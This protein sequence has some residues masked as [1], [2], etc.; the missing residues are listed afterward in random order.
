MKKFFGI[1]IFFINVVLVFSSDFDLEELSEKATKN[2]YPNAHEVLVKRIENIEYFR[3]GNYEKTSEEYFKILDKIGKD[4]NKFIYDS[5][6]SVYSDKKF[7]DVKII[8]DGKVLDFDFKS[9]MQLQDNPSD[10]SSN[11]YDENEKLIVIN[12]PDLKIGD[13]IYTKE[14]EKSKKTRMKG[15]YTDYIG[16]QDTYP[17][18]YSSTK[19]IGPMDNQLETSRVYDG[20]S[21]N[22]K[23]ENGIEGDKRWYRFT[24]FNVPQINREA[25]MP[26][27]I[28]VAMRWSVS[29]IP[30]WEEISKWY[31]SLSEPKIVIDD[32]VRRAASEISKNY[33][34]DRDK[35]KA[36]F[37]WVS[38]NVR[39]MGINREKNRPGLE[40][41]KSIYTLKSMTGVCRDKAALI[42]AMLRSLGY[43]SNMV[44]M[45]A[46]RQMEPDFP[47]N[48]FNHAIA[49]V[50]LGNEIILMDPTDETTKSLMPEYLS[51]RPYLVAKK[52]GD[53]LRSNTVVK[54]FSNELSI[55]S[56]VRY[57]GKEFLVKSK[58]N[59][60]GIND[61]SYRSYLINLK[62]DEREKFLKN[63]LKN[64]SADTELIS[65]KINP[66]NLLDDKDMEIN[67]EYR[68]KDFVVGDEYRMFR[69]PQLSGIFGMHNWM[70]GEFDL[71]ERRYPLVVN[72]TAS[73]REEVSVVM[74]GVNFLNIP[75]GINKNDDSF[76]FKLSYDVSSNKV[77][78][79]KNFSL[80]KLRYST[81]DYYEIRGI[82]GDIENYDKKYIIVKK[83]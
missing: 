58:L 26:S 44:L 41:H 59:F 37:F 21:G 83:R 25:Q 38:R 77:T 70:L 48:Y 36:V 82:L 7:E 67:M 50:K 61:N 43:D 11:I 24:V 53:T 1:L 73:F 46:S 40:P 2:A 3:D 17:I 54:P 12:V 27:I 8:R 33:E 45:N 20:I 65:F 9:G 39:Y 19:I 13:M 31:Y 5:Y 55:K 79:N 16:G 63:Q 66:E 74:D 68:I 28:E 80:N 23:L 22:Y 10:Q 64:L 76:S 14:Y 30:S 6:N 62:Y 51:G 72:S 42:V 15:N 60:F 75:K 18:I 35:I 34:D 49:S 29:T 78:L 52:D 4:N 56:E 71:S 69:I 81:K 47:N 32:Y 57:T